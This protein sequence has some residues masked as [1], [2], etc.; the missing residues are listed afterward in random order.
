MKK[1]INIYYIT[2][3]RADYGLM[4][5][6]LQKMEKHFSLSLVV[7]GMQLL[8]EFGNTITEIEKDRIKI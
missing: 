4:R 5:H 6:T 8:K 2:G 1:K 3:T 7:V